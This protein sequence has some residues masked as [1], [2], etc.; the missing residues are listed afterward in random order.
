MSDDM[1][2]EIARLKHEPPVYFYRTYEIVILPNPEKLKVRALHYQVWINRE[3]LRAATDVFPL[4]F[5][6]YAY[7]KQCAEKTIDATLARG[8]VLPQ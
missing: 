3:R 7:A 5:V 1:K 4:E 6:S 8:K 2:A